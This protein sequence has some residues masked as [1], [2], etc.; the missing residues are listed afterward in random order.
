MTHTW[1][2]RVSNLVLL[3]ALLLPARMTT[4]ATPAMAQ[5]SYDCAAVNQIP[6]SECAALVALYDATD[7]DTWTD[8]TNW[9]ATTTP[10]SWY[11]VT[12]TLGHVSWLS[13]SNNG[14]SGS[15]PSQVGD[16]TE[17]IVLYADRNQLTDLPARIGDLT[18]LQWLHVAFNELA[19]LPPEIGNL[20]A[21][22]SLYL[23]GNQLSQL[24]T[25]IGNL[26][27]LGQLLVEHNQLTSLPTGIEDCTALYKLWLSGNQLT[28][29]PTG[30]GY[31]TGLKD[32]Y[33][34]DNQLTALP[35]EIDT[36]TALTGLRLDGNQLTSLPTQIGSLNALKTLYLHGNQLTSVPS[37]VGNLGALQTLYLHD[38]ALTGEM[39]AFLTSLSQL[40]TFTFYD[41][42]WC[43]PSIGF[44]PLWLSG[45]PDLWGTGLICEDDLGTAGGTASQENTTSLAGMQA[46]MPDVIPAAGV[47]VNL[48]RSLPWNQWRLITTTHTIIDGAYQFANLGQGLGID[49][50]VQF[51]DPTRRLM[52]QYYDA[53]PTISTATVITI[54][55]G[56]P[57]IGIDAAMVEAHNIFL[58]MVLR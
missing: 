31:L 43:A 57:R 9:L 39:P 48:Y 23:S 10:C 52:P 35:T 50:R 42:D 6:Q 54:T 22:V 17:L 19:T 1:V 56:V 55:P 16:L 58:P 14:L 51:V 47:Q 29:L 40:T 15:I 37:E 49:Y 25:G 45:I 41:T 26:T 4:W 3:T 5:T 30:V 8:N 44:V 2:G 27:V 12:C 18:K 34:S 24:P 21:L 13:L 28:T 33:L 36:L 46:T 53:K 32:L 11:G 20:T 7:G 38:N